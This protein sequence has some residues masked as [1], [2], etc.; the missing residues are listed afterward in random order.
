MLPPDNQ[1]NPNDWQ[2]LY[3]TGGGWHLIGRIIIIMLPLFVGV[4]IPIEVAWYFS[5]LPDQQTTT[6][7]A[8]V[9]D[10]TGAAIPAVVAIIG[11]VIVLKVCKTFIIDFYQPSSDEGMTTLILRRL[12]GI[13]TFLLV[14]NTKLVPPDHPSTWLGGPYRLIINDGF[15]LYLERGHRFSRVVGPGFP[16][17]A[18]DAFETIKAVID[19]RLQVKEDLQITAWTKDGIEV[20]MRVRIEFRVGQANNSENVVTDSLLSPF[21]PLSVRKAAEYT[22]LRYNRFEKK[23]EESDWR[24]GICGRIR[25]FLAHHISSHYLDDLFLTDRIDNQVLHSKMIDGILE[26]LNDGLQNTGAHILNLQIVGAQIPDEV[27]SQRLAYWEAEK[28]SLVTRTNGE[29]RAFGIRAQEKA[30]AEAFHDLIVTIAEGLEKVAP[31]EFSESLLLSLSGILDQSLGDPM[32]RA[33]LARQKL[34]TLEK[35]QELLRG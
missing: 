23:F 11:L 32:L 29:S 12:F 8:R 16:T 21:D 17:P 19:L 10:Y 1:S 34:T 13:S 30:R 31:S 3:S 5:S 35:L 7:F 22:S 20:S 9:I 33:Y 6:F 18:L 15:A 28:K 14:N 25:G 24:D 27:H 4:I 26:R 2:T